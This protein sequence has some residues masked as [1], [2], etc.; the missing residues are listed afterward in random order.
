MA[1]GAHISIRTVFGHQ[2]PKPVPGINNII[3]AD[4][5]GGAVPF[6]KDGRPPVAASDR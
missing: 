2:S 1:F 6:L 4:D 3:I 5:K